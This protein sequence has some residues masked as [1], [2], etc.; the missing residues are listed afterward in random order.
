MSDVGEDEHRKGKA[1]KK[2]KVIEKPNTEA[3]KAAVLHMF[4]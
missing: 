3:Q 2:K 4:Q 1:K